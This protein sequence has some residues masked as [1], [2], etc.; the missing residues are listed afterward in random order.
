MN[1]MQQQAYV[2]SSLAI[3]LAGAACVV[4]SAALAAGLAYLVY[5]LNRSGSGD[6]RCVEE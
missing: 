2:Y 6:D 5:R 4:A 3:A 1:G